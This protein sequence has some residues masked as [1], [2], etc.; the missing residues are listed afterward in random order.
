MV[1]VTL[2]SKKQIHFPEIDKAARYSKA[3]AKKPIIP[4]QFFF[5]EDLEK[6]LTSEN[7]TLIQQRQPW[8]YHCNFYII[9][10]FY[11]GSDKI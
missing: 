3:A 8:H 4:A 1:M 6:I 7:E 9:I 10:M 2:A 5:I 11:D